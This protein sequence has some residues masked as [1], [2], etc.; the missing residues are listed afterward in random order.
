MKNTPIT[1]ENAIKEVVDVYTKGM[2]Y[3][4][5]D[6]ESDYA[7]WAAQD[8]S[9]LLKELHNMYSNRFTIIPDNKTTKVLYSKK[10]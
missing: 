6:V 5:D 9:I 8:N 4:T 10:G 1:R 2:A 7:W 3:S